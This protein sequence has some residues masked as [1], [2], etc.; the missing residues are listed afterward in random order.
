FLVVPVAV[1][2]DEAGDL[3]SVEVLGEVRGHVAPVL[4]AIHG[5]V[6]SDLLLEVDPLRGR[7]LL[8]GAA[9]SFRQ[10]SLGGFRPRTLKVFGLR[11]RTDARRQEPGRPATPTF[12]AAADR[13]RSFPRARPRRRNSRPSEADS[14]DA[15]R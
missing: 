15:F 1:G 13:I 8:E 7:L 11:E 14:T 3:R 12:L 10:L 9:P 5:A 4:F 2:A 6:D